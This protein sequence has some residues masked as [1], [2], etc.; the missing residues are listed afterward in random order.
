MC[1]LT[2]KTRVRCCMKASPMHR[3]R[4]TPNPCMPLRGRRWWREGMKSEAVGP[5]EETEALSERT[6][7]SSVVPA[8]MVWP[9]TV[10]GTVVCCGALWGKSG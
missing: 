6:S 4:P 9:A 8:G 3:R 1:R 7:N 5:Q 2:R 10:R